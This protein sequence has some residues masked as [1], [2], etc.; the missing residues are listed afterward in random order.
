VDTATLEVD[1]L[2]SV[3]NMSNGDK[4][5]S[6]KSLGK[7]PA[8]D[9]QNSTAMARPKRVLPSRSRRGGPGIGSCDVDALIL[10][11]QKRKFDN[12]PIVPASA[13]I[14]LTTNSTLASSSSTSEPSLNDNAYERYFDRPEVSEAYKKQQI[15]ETPE[16][17]LLSEDASVGGR[18]RPRALEDE[19]ADT[20]DAMYEKRHRKYETF[21][22]RQRFREKEKLKHEQYKLKERIEQLRG[23]DGAAFLSLP[24]AM[25]SSSSKVLDDDDPGIQDLPG[26]HINGAALYNEGERRR[27]V[28]L[29]TAATLED[30][31]RVLLPPDRMKGMEKEKKQTVTPSDSADPETRGMR[32]RSHGG[33]SVV[34]VDE[35]PV[36][37]PVEKLKL[38]IKFPTRDMS[39]GDGLESKPAFPKK[40]S[41]ARLS[42]TPIS[43]PK[44]RSSIHESPIA[45]DNVT[46]SPEVSPV[47]SFQKPSSSVTNMEYLPSSSSPHTDQ[48]AP[49]KRARRGTGL[50]ASASLP[51]DHQQEEFH[52]DEDPDT[53]GSPRRTRHRPPLS[54]ASARETGS[55]LMTVAVRSSG[56]GRKSQ[57]TQRHVTAFGM[58]LH[59]EL[60]E[61]RD[62]EIPEW[63]R[64]T[65]HIMDDMPDVPPEAHS[66]TWFAEQVNGGRHILQETVPGS[67]PEIDS[68][69][70]ETLSCKDEAVSELM[71]E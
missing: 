46:V 5:P 10:D 27:K 13:G 14:L 66:D 60:E 37:P 17:S 8:V 19:L 61:V 65:V 18:F 11:A 56:S 50:S 25:F 70:E 71:S 39:L 29:E 16:F 49:R 53:K 22:K 58:K 54:D 3:L 12:E 64:K 69:M 20:S 31:Y 62:F 55:V 42:T 32:T 15:I 26:I 35:A 33:E 6:Q 63:I 7:R 24:A 2:F 4:H 59:P 41:S 52:I 9:A 51:D 21:E 34:D 68:T 30:R 57:R 36:E 38:K 23:M 40:R 44:T 48:D 45:V 1:T 28:I 47:V 67:E 43:R